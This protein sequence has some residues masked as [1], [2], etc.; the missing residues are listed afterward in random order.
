MLVVQESRG[1]LVD[2]LEM[3]ESLPCAS[4]RGEEFGVI[5]AIQAPCQEISQI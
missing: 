2:L 3:E 1:G 5:G 4:R